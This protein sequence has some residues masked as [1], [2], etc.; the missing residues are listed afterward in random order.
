MGQE[1]VVG[2]G[3]G[4]LFVEFDPAAVEAQFE[5]VEFGLVGGEG[6]VGGGGSGDEALSKAIRGQRIVSMSGP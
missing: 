4:L 3:G 5:M 1:F 6:G 2:V